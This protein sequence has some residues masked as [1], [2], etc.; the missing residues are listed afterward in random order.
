MKFNLKRLS[1]DLEFVEGVGGITEIYVP[2]YHYAGINGVQV[3]VSDG[4]WLYDRERQSL[5]WWTEKKEGTRWLKLRVD[6]GELVV[7]EEEGWGLWWVF[8]VV[9]LGVAVVVG[10]GFF[11]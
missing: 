8:G 6:E 3:R 11:K 7:D 1:F 5:F 9:V 10:R 4:E 2:N